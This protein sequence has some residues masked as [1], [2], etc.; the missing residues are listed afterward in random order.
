ML[1]SRIGSGGCHPK[2]EF[3]TTEELRNL[4][5]YFVCSVVTLYNGDLSNKILN[6]GKVVRYYK[7]RYYKENYVLGRGRETG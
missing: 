1:C 7:V 4:I 3:G 2:I 6:K 5:S